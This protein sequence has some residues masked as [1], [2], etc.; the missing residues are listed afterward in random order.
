MG[1][2]QFPELGHLLNKVK[3]CHAIY[4]RILISLPSLVMTL[5]WACDE[6]RS[7]SNVLTHSTLS[8][9]KLHFPFTFE[10]KSAKL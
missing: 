8:T 5:N 4:F 2:S 10:G 6:R 7:E 1:M 3:L 9:Q